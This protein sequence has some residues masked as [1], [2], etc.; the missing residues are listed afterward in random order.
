MQTIHNSMFQPGTIDNLYIRS[1]V[2]EVRIWTSKNFL[3]LND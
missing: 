2:E 1:C 3:K